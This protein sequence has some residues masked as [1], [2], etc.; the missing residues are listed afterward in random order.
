[1]SPTTLDFRRLLASDLVDGFDA[2]TDDGEVRLTTFFRSYAQQN[3]K[4][5]QSATWVAA[6]RV[7]IAGY[8]TLCPGSASPQSLTEL[9]RGLPRNA[10]A[11][12]V[13]ARMATDARYRGQGVGSAMVDR[14]VMLRADHLASEHGC[15][16]VFTD[17]KPGAV[18]FY[19]K[20]AFHRLLGEVLPGQNVPMFRPL[21]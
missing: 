1:M 10:V 7:S 14:V 11:V 18:G 19:E 15:V 17:A 5:R 9:V 3:Q 4:R 12:L 16:G 2:G 21:R 20:K 6:D 13:L 8:V